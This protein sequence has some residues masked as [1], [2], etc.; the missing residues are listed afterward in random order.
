[1]S[2]T[3]TYARYS[4]NLTACASISVCLTTLVAVKVAYETYA[5]K[6]HSQFY[7]VYGLLALS[8]TFWLPSLLSQIINDEQ[9]VSFNLYA[10][11]AT[12]PC[13][14]LE[15]WLFC[16]TYYTGIMDS[17]NMRV[18]PDLESKMQRWL[19]NGMVW[20]STAVVFGFT[21]HY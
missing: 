3:N 1:M 2:C 6:D 19:I 20:V 7:V 16:W 4:T 10:L 12:N 17:T 15:I 13:G 11:Q 14:I 21:F 5:F 8:M 9:L 18:A